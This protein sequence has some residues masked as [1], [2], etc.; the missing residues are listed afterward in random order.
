MKKNHLHPRTEIINTKQKQKCRQARQTALSW[1]TRR[2]PIAF[3]TQRSIQ[4][5]K[6]GIMEDILV[7][8][9]EANS[10][11]ISRSKL[12]QAVVVFTRRIDYLACLKAQ[13]HRIDLEGNIGA[14]VTEEEAQRAAL[15][16]KK[17]VEKSIK[18]QKKNSVEQTFQRSYHP[19]SNE[20]RPFYASEKELSSPKKIEVVFKTKP[21]KTIDPDAVERLKS[22]LGLTKKTKEAEMET[23][24]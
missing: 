6:V 14:L 20:T 5:L 11:G 7:F 1:L 3:D 4:P 24:A 19:T 9:E 16:I 22:K 8:A 23:M 13:E 15:K 10:L 18:N 12:R 21:P 2:F 17:I